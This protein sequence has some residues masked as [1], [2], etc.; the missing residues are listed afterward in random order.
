MRKATKIS[1]AWKILKKVNPDIALL[2]EVMEIPQE[3]QAE[4]SILSKTAIYKTGKNQK[5]KTVVMVK[6]E[7]LK[8]ISLSAEYDRVNKE[9]EF[10]KG[11]IV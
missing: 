9:L 11:N 6:G 4:Y 1:P 5:F 10:F 7:I 3:I 8:E 2:Q